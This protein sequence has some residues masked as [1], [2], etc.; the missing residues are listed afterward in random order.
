M[1]KGAAEP[2]AP[3][4]GLSHTL[5]T[6]SGIIKGWGEQYSYC[7]E[8]NVFQTLDQE[9][10]KL[11]RGYLGRYSS[12]RSSTSNSDVQRRLLGIALLADSEGQMIKWVLPNID[13]HH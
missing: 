4:Y 6:V 8:R 9:I 5:T 3:K 1:D 12:I 7:N 11:L 13:L 2:I 10:D